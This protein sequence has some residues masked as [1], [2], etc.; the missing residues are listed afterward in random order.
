MSSEKL[1]EAI[2]G[3]RDEFIEEAMPGN[4][5][6]K[7]SNKNWMKYTALAACFCICMIA[8]LKLGSGIF[9]MGKMESA[10]PMK[11]CA[12]EESAAEEAA[13]EMEEA[14]TDSE[15]E[16]ADGELVDD[17]VMEEAPAPEEVPEGGWAEEEAPAED[18]PADD[19]SE[20][21][22]DIASGIYF[23]DNLYFPISFQERKDYGLIDSNATGLTPEN[24]YQITK[25]DLGKVMGTVEE[26]PGNPDLVGCTIY[27]FKKFPNDKNICIIDVHGEYEFYVAE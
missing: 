15:A 24:T 20:E 8:V 1:L 18:V 10:A 11:D 3:I 22:H 14:V 27:Q 6:K 2:G 13:P 21:I 19:N 25:S 17:A 5:V 23:G 9:S 12:V 7:K 16:R 26:C 4:A